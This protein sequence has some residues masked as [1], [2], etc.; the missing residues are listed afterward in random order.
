MVAWVCTKCSKATMHPILDGVVENCPDCYGRCE[1]V[2]GSS[3]VEPDREIEERDNR[4]RE[5]AERIFVE[6]VRAL[7]IEPSPKGDTQTD[8]MG[9]IRKLK[10]RAW[11]IARIWYEEEN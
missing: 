2:P 6:L 5:T 4:I 1:I 8:V 3:F 7:L 11:E 9:D 10:V